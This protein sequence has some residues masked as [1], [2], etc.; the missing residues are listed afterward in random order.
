VLAGRQGLYLLR[1]LDDLELIRKGS[2]NDACFLPSQAGEPM[3]LVA[4]TAQGEVI[5]IESATA[6]PVK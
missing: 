5:R 2:F 1:S 3:S 4:A 6:S